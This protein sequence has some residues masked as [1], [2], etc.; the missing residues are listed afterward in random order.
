[1]TPKQIQQLMN[2]KDI[3]QAE[4]AL[5]IDHKQPTVSSWVNDIS[6]PRPRAVREM[7]RVARLKP[8]QIRK[9][10]KRLTLD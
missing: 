5:L 8:S 7:E 2:D 6:A 4:L 9:K 1:M 3:N 10:L